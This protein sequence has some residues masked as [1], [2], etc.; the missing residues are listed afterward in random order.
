MRQLLFLKRYAVWLDM[1][2][3]LS[4][5]AAQFLTDEIVVHKDWKIDPSLT[6][7]TLDLK[8]AYQNIACSDKTKWSSVLVIWDMAKQCPTFFISDALMFGRAIWHIAF[9]DAE[10]V[11]HQVLWWFPVTGDVADCSTTHETLRVFAVDSWMESSMMFSRHWRCRRPLYYPE[12]LRVFAVDS[13]ME[14]F[15]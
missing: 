12:M 14:S 8:T 10:I 15:R 2:S 1:F 9:F 5:F 4:L 13:W 3:N 6:G 11:G 7:R